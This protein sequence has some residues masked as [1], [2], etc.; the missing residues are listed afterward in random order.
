MDEHE[1]LA[2]THGLVVDLTAADG[3]SSFVGSTENDIVTKLIIGKGGR[4]QFGRQGLSL[5]SRNTPKL[6]D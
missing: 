3:P 1:R 5:V 2:F 4:G 6:I